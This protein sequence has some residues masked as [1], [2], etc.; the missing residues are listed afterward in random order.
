MPG[1]DGTGP[2]GMGPM[3]GR[4]AGYCAGSSAPAFASPA[5]GRGFGRGLGLGFRGGRGRRWAPPQ[6]AYGHAYGAPYA[7][8]YGA[9]PTRQQENEALQNQAEYLEESLEGIKKQ[10]AELEAKKTME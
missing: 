8:P 10:I 7:G 1:G 4:G 6:A 5:F 3:T 9:T 2:A